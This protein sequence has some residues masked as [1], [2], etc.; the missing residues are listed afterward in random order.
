[1]KDRT[2]LLIA[3]R[4]STLHLADRI[5]VLDDG[6]IVDQGPHD[7]LFERSRLY[8]MLLSGLDE[9]QAE[10]IGDRIEALAAISA[11]ADGPPTASAWTGGTG[12]GFAV[13]IPRTFGPPSIGPG[14]GGVEVA[15]EEGRLA[16]Q[17]SADARTAGPGGGPPAG[18][19]RGHRRPRPR[20]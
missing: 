2:T 19:R 11:P 1:M 17:P 6:R 14:L 7:E 13:P 12:A 8:R 9:E 20:G 16:A 5:V 18:P 15:V 4:R 10:E 3:H